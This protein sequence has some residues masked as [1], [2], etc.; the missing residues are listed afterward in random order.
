MSETP[1]ALPVATGRKIAGRLWRMLAGRRKRLVGILTLF[2]IEAAT[3]VV[4]PMVIGSLVDTVMNSNGSGVPGAFWWQICLLV[5]AALIA[6]TITWIATT[7]LARLSETVLAE[8][9]EAFV[10][11]ALDLP[12][13][14]IEQ[15]GTGDVVTRASDDIAQA[16]GTL[17]EVVQ[18][19]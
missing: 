15:A 16:S 18:N 7:A 11:A 4:F 6:G 19:S 3:A 9:R 2:L 17:P 8:L 10:T 12:R 1:Q 5:V 14:T 13:A